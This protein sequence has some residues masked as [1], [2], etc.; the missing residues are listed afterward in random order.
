[1]LTV[2]ARVRERP[3]DHKGGY[4]LAVDTV[5]GTGETYEDAVAAARRLVPEGWQVLYLK[6]ER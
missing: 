3:P 5:T 1:M 4:D 6:V 2:E